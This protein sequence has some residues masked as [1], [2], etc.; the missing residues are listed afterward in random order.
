[1]IKFL[2]FCLCLA[3]VAA[4]PQRGD[5]NRRHQPQEFGPRRVQS[6]GRRQIPQA[7][8]RF[9]R[10]PEPQNRKL[11]P[12]PTNQRQQKRPVPVRQQERQADPRR[13]QPS[14][15]LRPLVQ[16][17]KLEERMD[18]EPVQRKEQRPVV[19]EPV[20][21]RTWT[22]S[23]DSLEGESYQPTYPEKRS[24]PYGAEERLSPYGAEERSSSYGAEERSSS[25]G[26]PPEQANL[27][28]AVAL[29]AANYIP[30]NYDAPKRLAFQIHGQD[31]PNSYRYG[32]DTGVGYNRQFKYEEKDK[33]GV[34]KGRYGYY[35][36]EGKL[37]IVNYTSDPKT[38]FHADGDFVP[39]PQY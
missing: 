34:L 21:D 32:Y 4:W 26:A 31:G 27:E 1:M 3:I 22:D 29:G 37:Q 10:Q 13:N 36:Q 16:Q 12:V 35:D 2:P 20:P 6:D 17:P 7:Q 38:G 23:E 28:A 24:S 9:R 39:K 19:S 15:P 8:E 5:Y 14:R 11:I 18:I 33:Y 25:Y 30:E